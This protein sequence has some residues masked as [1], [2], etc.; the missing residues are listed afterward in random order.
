MLVTYFK[1]IVKFLY[2]LEK[3]FIVDAYKIIKAQAF[4]KNVGVLADL[5]HTVSKKCP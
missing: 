3:W 4:C 5:I 2:H 1:D